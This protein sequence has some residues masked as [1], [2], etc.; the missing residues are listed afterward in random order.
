MGP[1]ILQEKLEIK[2]GIILLMHRKAFV[3]LRSSKSNLSSLQ[4]TFSGLCLNEELDLKMSLPRKSSGFGRGAV[5]Y[6]YFVVLHDV[7][8]PMLSQSP[9]SNSEKGREAC[10]ESNCSG[11]CWKVNHIFDDVD[12]E[13][14]ALSVINFILSCRLSAVFLFGK[15]CAVMQ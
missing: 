4:E 12:D 13:G 5:L 14:T 11:F 15:L 6:F 1:S 8:T 3:A 7:P 10:M 2:W 9:S